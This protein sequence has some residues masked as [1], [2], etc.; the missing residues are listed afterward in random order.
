MGRVR[1]SLVH[2]KGFNLNFSQKK[3]V[4]F[5]TISRVNICIEGKVTGP[6]TKGKGL[7]LAKENKRYVMCYE[8]GVTGKK[9]MPKPLNK[10]NI[11]STMTT[12]AGTPEARVELEG[13]SSL[14]A[15]VTRYVE[16]DRV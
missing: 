13:S 16:K 1:Q 3:G 10:G 14:G 9:Q 7:G 2:C 4:K 11:L 12:C 5:A 8:K 15:R 6:Q